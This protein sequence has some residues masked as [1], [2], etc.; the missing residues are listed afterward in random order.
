MSTKIK[1]SEENAI[2]MAKLVYI[3]F[4]TGYFP[5]FVILAV[6]IAYSYR[7]DGPEWVDSHFTFQIR[8]FWL[9]LL[10]MIPLAILCFLPVVGPVI[11]IILIAPFSFLRPIRGL[12]YLD[13]KLPHPKPLSFLLG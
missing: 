10:Y 13:E 3:L 4:A 9:G 8:T 7:G 5:P 12:K 2:R 6:F 1:V 11:A